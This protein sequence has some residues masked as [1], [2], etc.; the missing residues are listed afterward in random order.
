MGITKRRKQF[1][2]EI[3]KIY[4]DTLLPVHYETIANSIGVSKWTAYDVMK[5]L[6]KDGYLERTYVKN[7]SDTGRSI[8]VFIPTKKVIDLYV[9]DQKQS[10]LKE[11]NLD[12][13]ESMHINMASME[14]YVD[15][16]IMDRIAN[17]FG[18]RKLTTDT[19]FCCYYLSKLIYFLNKG[20]EETKG[21][22]D[23]SISASNN[24]YV[25]I[26][27]FVGLSLAIIMPAENKKND[28]STNELSSQFFECLDRLE[29]DELKILVFFLSE[30]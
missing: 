17:K 25:Q 14:K 29:A 1:L 22:T 9:N 28:L 11:E 5:V 16:K 6:E 8:V 23:F 3:V 19:Q 24:P 13:K 7:E 10:S 18:N 21:I 30:I 26:S 20:G 4:Q 2:E 27:I 15:K 12:N